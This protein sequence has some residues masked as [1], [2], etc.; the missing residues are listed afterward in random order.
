[1]LTVQQAAQRVRRSRSTIELW[2][3]SGLL[4]VTVVR[5]AKGTVIRRYLDEADLMSVLREKLESNPTHPRP[6][7]DRT[8]D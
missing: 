3:S 5:N 2:I 8:P 7:H 1:M 6:R 4:D